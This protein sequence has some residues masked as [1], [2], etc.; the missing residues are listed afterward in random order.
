MGEE[1]FLPLPLVLLPLLVFLFLF[2]L[3]RRRR[4]PTP[5]ESPPR[6]APEATAKET[7]ASSK[8]TTSRRC[9]CYGIFPWRSLRGRATEEEK[10]AN[11]TF[12]PLL[13][14]C[15]RHEQRERQRES[16]K[17]IFFRVESEKKIF[18]FK[19]IQAST[20]ALFFL[21]SD[22]GHA[23]FRNLTPLGAVG[24]S[25]RSQLPPM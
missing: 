11:R 13:F 19:K 22:E 12:F 3:R 16:E 5:G 21:F 9:C 17:I 25:P 2:A 1:E 10:R 6:E 8:T 23:G 14:F 15:A 18:R 4:S 20:L 24:S 7:M